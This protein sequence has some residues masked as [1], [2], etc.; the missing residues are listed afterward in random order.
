[1]VVVLIAVA[2]VAVLLIS[3]G[4][5]QGP[6]IKAEFTNVRGLL[7]NNDVRLNGAKVGNVK[8]IDLTKRGTAMVTMQLDKGIPMPRIDA[9]ATVRPVD[10]LG[11]IYLSYSPGVGAQPLTGP[12]PVSRTTNIPRLADLLRSFDPGARA[13]MQAMIVELSDGLEQRGVDLNRA[14]VELRPALHAVDRVMTELGSQNA[15]LRGLIT[16]SHH[17]ASQLTEHNGALDQTVS[18]FASTL[19]ETAQHAGGIDRGLQRLAPTLSELRGTT[20]RLAT[21]AT[22][23]QPL[24]VQLARAAP[25][26]SRAATRLPAFLGD[27]RAAVRGAHPALTQTQA[28]LR[29]GRKTFPALRRSVDSLHR[30]AGDFDSVT[31]T[32]EPLTPQVSSALFVNVADETQEPGDQPLDPTTDPLQHYWRGAA[33]LSCQSFGLRIAPGCANDLIPGAV[34]HRTSSRHTLQL[35]TVRRPAIKL[36][37]LP[38]TPKLPRLPQIKTGIG[39]VDRVLSAAQSLTKQRDDAAPASSSGDHDVRSLLNY[40]LG[41]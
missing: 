5:S 4:G 23:L 35:P 3:S 29:A 1:V 10:L 15:S 41:P 12:I 40:L 21:T 8:A 31:R 25:G 17:V 16:D 6:E 18:S 19:R 24:A 34:K 32:L 28:L 38:V 20:G 22:E 11:D 36:P 37:R 14:A 2:V 27:A 33:V 9:A 26:L 13:G 39:P 30:A 7:A